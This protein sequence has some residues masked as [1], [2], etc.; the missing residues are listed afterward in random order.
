MRIRNA[1]SGEGGHAMRM[2][3]GKGERGR[4]LRRCLPSDEPTAPGR[5][6]PE[7]GLPRRRRPPDASLDP[8]RVR[9]SFIAMFPRM[10]EAGGDVSLLNVRHGLRPRLAAGEQVLHVAPDGGAQCC[11]R[12]FSVRSPGYWSSSIVTSRCTGDPPSSGM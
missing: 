7:V 5:G 1:E 4:R 10:H 6:A 2:G 9:P 3:M 8:T 11:S 12:S